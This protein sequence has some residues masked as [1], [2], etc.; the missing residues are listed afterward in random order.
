MAWSRLEHAT[1]LRGQSRPNRT[2]TPRRGCELGPALQTSA[3]R[4]GVLSLDLDTFGPRVVHGS[5]VTFDMSALLHL[6]YAERP[7]VAVDTPT[8]LRLLH[9]DVRPHQTVLSNL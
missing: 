5:D 8:N 3:S 4:A 1:G 9:L 2:D 7:D 6:D